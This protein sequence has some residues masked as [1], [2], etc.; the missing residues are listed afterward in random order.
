MHHHTP[1]RFPYI[2][3]FLPIRQRFRF[4]LINLDV[5]LANF[6]FFEKTYFLSFAAATPLQRVMLLELKQLKQMVANTALQVQDIFK[7][8]KN[9]A[10]QDDI[11]LPG[12]VELPLDSLEAIKNIEEE[13]HSSQNA[14][15]LVI[16]FFI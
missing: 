13:L 1:N 14:N 8:L 15:I 11:D 12:S 4:F 3:Y 9:E 7:I 5:L 10:N 2:G 16:I 6:S